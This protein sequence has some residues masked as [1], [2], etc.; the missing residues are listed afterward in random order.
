MSVE[1]HLLSKQKIL[2]KNINLFGGIKK[3]LTFAAQTTGD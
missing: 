3:V 2:K 1:I